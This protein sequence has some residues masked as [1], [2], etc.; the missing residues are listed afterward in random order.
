M[1]KPPSGGRTEYLARLEILKKC[2]LYIDE[3]KQ[4][5]LAQHLYSIE[6]IPDAY[7]APEV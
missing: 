6:R 2:E 5:Y 3:N 1:P 7:G 4:M